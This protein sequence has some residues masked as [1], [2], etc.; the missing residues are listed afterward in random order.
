[1]SVSKVWCLS[2]DNPLLCFDRGQFE[3]MCA[4]ILSRVEAPLRSILEQ[5]SK[6]PV[7]LVAVLMLLE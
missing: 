7:V 3:D 2:A 6:Y 1:M 4:D 5:A